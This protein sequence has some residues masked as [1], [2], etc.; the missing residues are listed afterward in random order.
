MAGTITTAEA[1]AMFAVAPET[2]WRWKRQGKLTPVVPGSP[3][4]SDL[5]D[6]AQVLGLLAG[7]PA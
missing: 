2:V 1:A 5:Y 4:R 3:G 7:D 6:R